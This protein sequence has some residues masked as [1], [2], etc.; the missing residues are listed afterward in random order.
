MVTSLSII[1]A[2]Y[3]EKGL[4]LETVKEIV[5]ALEGSEFDSEIIVIDDASNDGT[6]EFCREAEKINPIVKY[7]R[8]KINMGFGGVF[9]MGLSMAIKEWYMILPGDNAYDSHNIHK[10]LENVKKSDIVIPYITNIE[11]RGSKRYIISKSFTWIMNKISGLKLNYYNGPVIHRTKSIQKQANF[12]HSFAFQAEILC[13]S[14]WSG[15]SFTQ[16]GVEIQESAGRES[17]ALKIKNVLSVISTLFRLCYLR[18]GSYS[19]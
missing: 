19:A 9:Y 2:A 10:I 3:N 8:N 12:T 16:V 1:V 4:I 17:N 13:Q 15:G 5:K 7:H 11:I 18:Y 14:I 6:D